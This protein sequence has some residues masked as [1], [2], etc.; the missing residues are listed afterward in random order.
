M[1]SAE[2]RHSA[3]QTRFSTVCE[4]L[5]QYV[6]RKHGG[7]HT[8]EITLETP[9]LEVGLIDSLS[10]M[11]FILHLENHY[12]LDFMA[13]DITR[14]EFATVSTLAAFVVDNLGDP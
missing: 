6:V 11:T 5:L 12:E 14:S 13:I 1:E 9:L 10:M 7:R 3:A 2:D 8:E 4:E